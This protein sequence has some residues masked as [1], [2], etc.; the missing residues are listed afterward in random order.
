MAT[1]EIQA[2]D[3]NIL[4]RAV[5]DDVPEQRKRIFR[6]LLDGHD[7]YVSAHVITEA[8]FTMERGKYK[9]SRERIVSELSLL[10]SNDCFVYDEEL[11]DRVFPYYIRHPA[12][13]FADCLLS[14]EIKRKQCEPLWTF[15]KDFTKQSLVAKL[16]P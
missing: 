11:F 13:S 10:F 1:N 3:T 12:L 8:V 4:L 6:L 2:V 15:D 5:I 9:L 16:V 7:Y 14:F